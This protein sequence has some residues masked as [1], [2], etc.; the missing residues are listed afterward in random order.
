MRPDWERYKNAAPFRR[1]DQMLE[2]LPKA[3]V[4]CPGSGVNANLVEKARKMGIK[5]WAIQ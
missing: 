5:I 3:V 2:M 4:A 1:K